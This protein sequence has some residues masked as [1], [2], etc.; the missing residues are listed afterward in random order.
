M[1]TKG[2]VTAAVFI[3][4]LKR[5][6]VN[7]PA[8]IFVIVDGHPTHRAKSAWRHSRGSGPCIRPSTQ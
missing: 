8:P 2:R 6:L 7:A 4:F 3:D 5:L 1:L